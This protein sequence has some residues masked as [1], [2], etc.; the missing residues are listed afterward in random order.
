MLSSWRGSHVPLAVIKS[1][2]GAKA[3]VRLAPKDLSILSSVVLRAFLSVAAPTDR[4]SSGAAPQRDPTSLIKFTRVTARSMADCD[5]LPHCVVLDTPLPPD[6]R[7]GFTQGPLAVALFD[8]SLCLEQTVVGEVA[9]LSTAGVGGVPR[10]ST[11]TPA[12]MEQ[13]RLAVLAAELV[14]HG[15][16]L[17]ASQRLIHPWLKQRLGALG[18]LV[19][20]R[21]SLHH[22]GAVQALT[23]AVT[24]SAW[25][26]P[27]ARECLGWVAKAECV[28]LH[29][30]R[31]LFLTG[32]SGASV[33]TACVPG[34]LEVD[35]RLEAVKAVAH[36]RS[37]PMCTV[38]LCAPTAHALEELELAVVVRVVSGGHPS[39]QLF[40]IRLATTSCFFLRTLAAPVLR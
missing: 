24:L 34:E 1:V 23:G 37:Q 8:V 13:D 19:L 35:E 26:R 14:G 12:S 4:T 9:V 40:L 20:E 16:G 2:V 5:A 11:W 21:L 33:H 10:A 32:A 15:V 36:A 7:T 28:I 6:V 39:R 17:L 38:V 31:V 25:D 30:Q 18:V 22:I 3:S 27:V 29:G